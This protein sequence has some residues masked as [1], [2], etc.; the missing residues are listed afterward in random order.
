MALGPLGLSLSE[1]MKMTPGEIEELKTGFLYREERAHRRLGH[2]LCSILNTQRK[3]PI[4][5]DRWIGKKT[6]TL[7][8]ER[9]ER[10]ERKRN[11]ARDKD[12]K[13][14]SPGMPGW[15][16]ELQKMS[17]VQRDWTMNLYYRKQREAEDVRSSD[18][19]TTRC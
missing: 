7:E 17:P 15:E 11:A 13:L 6:F 4:E 18:G 1:F 9:L 10:E 3:R 16:A 5:L 14:M 12:D 8:L 19:D 2:M